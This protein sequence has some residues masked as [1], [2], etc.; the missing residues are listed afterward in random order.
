MKEPCITTLPNKII[1]KLTSLCTPMTFGSDTTIIYLNHIPM[2]GYLL[3]KGHLDILD[4]KANLIK[5]FD[6]NILI[7]AKESLEQINFKYIAKIQAGS[8]VSILDRNII[9]NHLLL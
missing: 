6:Q 3:I 8:V 2:A 5:S 7:G 4:Q 1:H 9:K